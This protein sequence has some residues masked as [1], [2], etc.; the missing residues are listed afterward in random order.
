MNLELASR[1]RAAINDTVSSLR[2]APGF[3]PETHATLQTHLDALLK[4]ELQALT[5][6]APEADLADT[7]GYATCRSA[8]VSTLRNMG[9]VWRG[10][11]LW[12]PPIGEVPSR[13]TADPLGRTHIDPR[14]DPVPDADRA[15][16]RVNLADV[17]KD[18]PWYPDDSGDWVEVPDDCTTC[19]VP[20]DT[21]INYLLRQEREEQKYHEYRYVA[22]RLNWRLHPEKSTRIVA[23]KVVKP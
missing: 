8:A 21:H 12:A 10:G 3:P 15:A 6:Q 19:P 4:T 13:F 7:S 23:Y 14:K 17:V 11:V 16:G 2:P 22:H 5:G 1:I 18:T 9:Y 20:D